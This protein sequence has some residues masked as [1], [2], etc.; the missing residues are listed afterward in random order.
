MQSL[1]ATV[2]IFFVLVILGLGEAVIVASLGATTFIIFA[3]PHRFTARPRNVI[4]GHVAGLLSGYLCAFLIQV[5]PWNHY[6]CNAALYALSVGLVMFVMVIT[7]TEHPPAAGTALG[8][9]IEGYNPDVIITVLGAALLLS[10]VRWQ[11][12]KYM[13][14]LR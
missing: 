1:F 12:R 13:R 9:C 3:L 5:L 8:V 10:Y 11:F 6:A 4:G 2:S 7:D 14:D